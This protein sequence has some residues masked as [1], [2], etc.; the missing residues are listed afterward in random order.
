MNILI[1][2][3]MRAAK[4]EPE[5][6]DEVKKDPAAL[7]QALKVVLLSAACGGFGAISKLGLPAIIISII[8]GLIS[9][10]VWSVI[11]YWVGIKIFSE[12]QNK[13]KVEDLLRV[14]G[15]STSAGVIRIFA[16]IDSIQQLVFS[17]AAA[18]MPLAGCGR[19][20]AGGR[21]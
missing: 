12:S 3:M 10:Y 8:L 5:L 15:F 11:I 20:W 9:W 18:W 21:T 7:G 6:Y 16:A 17:L 14:I 13:I 2:R 1:Q 4:L 19:S